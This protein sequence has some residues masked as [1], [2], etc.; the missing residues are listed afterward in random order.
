M[1]RFFLRFFLDLVNAPLLLT[2]HRRYLDAVLALDAR[3]STAIGCGRLKNL[4]NKCHHELVVPVARLVLHL[5]PEGITLPMIIN[6]KFV[7]ISVFMGQWGN[8]AVFALV[9]VRE[10]GVVGGGCGG[11]SSSAKEAL[12]FFALGGAL[13]RCSGGGGGSCGVGVIEGMVGVSFV[14]E[15]VRNVFLLLD[16]EVDLEAL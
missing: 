9:V 1:Q 16:I 5:V 15:I 8:D 13:W 6:H 3:A 11:G 10:V 14:V 12:D 2:Q 7:L 4:F